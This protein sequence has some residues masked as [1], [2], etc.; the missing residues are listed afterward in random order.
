MPQ[1]VGVG[2][3]G[4]ATPAIGAA[5]LGDLKALRVALRKDARAVQRMNKHGESAVTILASSPRGHALAT[6]I[7]SYRARSPTSSSRFPHPR[8]GHR[9]TAQLPCMC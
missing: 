2:G 7:S 6:R 3:M 5:V 1:V 8:A 4:D 9:Y